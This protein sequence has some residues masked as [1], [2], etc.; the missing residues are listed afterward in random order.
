MRPA[1]GAGLLLCLPIRVQM[2]GAGAKTCVVVRSAG[3]A[4]LIGYPPISCQ[5][6]RRSMV[7]GFHAE[8][9][10][11]QRGGPA[12]LLPTVASTGQLPAQV[13][14]ACHTTSSQ[15]GAVWQQ[16]LLLVSWRGWC[17]QILHS[18]IYCLPAR[19]LAWV[20]PCTPAV[21]HCLHNKVRSG[22]I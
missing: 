4:G 11:T 18:R 3:K 20:L 10:S 1:G 2:D 8:G 14:L 21:M 19:L 7:K 16:N 12:C 13:L 5:W 9:W 6:G 22:D 17:Q 15:T